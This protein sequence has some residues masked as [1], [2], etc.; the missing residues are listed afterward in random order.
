MPEIVLNLCLNKHKLKT[1]LTCMDSEA[2]PVVFFLFKIFCN[3]KKIAE[4]YKDIILK[5][6]SELLILISIC[7]T[8]T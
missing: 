3:R 8:I 1:Y 7:K 5:L 2:T 4:V 6:S